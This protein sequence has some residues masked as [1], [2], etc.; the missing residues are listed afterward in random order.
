[1]YL[2]SLIYKTHSVAEF[3]NFRS[4]AHTMATVNFKKKFLCP[5]DDEWFVLADGI[6]TLA[7][8]HYRISDPERN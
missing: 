7:H 4:R 5:E 6:T 2:H 3:K 8:F 1:M